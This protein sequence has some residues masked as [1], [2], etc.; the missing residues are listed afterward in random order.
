ML[1]RGNQPRANP[2]L[3]STTFGKMYPGIYCTVLY[4]TVPYLQLNTYL[5]CKIS[6]LFVFNELVGFDGATHTRPFSRINT[7]NE[8]LRAPCRPSLFLSS[9]NSLYTTKGYEKSS[10][11]PL[12]KH[13]EEKYFISEDRTHHHRSIPHT[14]RSFAAPL[15]INN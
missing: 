1:T 8:A 2:A 9:S 5:G 7:Q 3:L 10:L 6:E 12:V 15:L 11:H 13:P 14:H 4:C